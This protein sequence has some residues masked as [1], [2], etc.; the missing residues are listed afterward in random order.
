M[1]QLDPNCL[2]LSEDQRS[3]LKQLISEYVPNSEVW[4]Y[5]SRITGHSHEGS[6]LDLVLRNPSALEVPVRGSSE[7]KEAI[8]ASSLPMLIDIHQWAYLPESFKLNIEQA[9]VLLK[10]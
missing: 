9:Y 6:D 4:A 5:G 3:L 1:P 8:S 10:G 2:K 7:L